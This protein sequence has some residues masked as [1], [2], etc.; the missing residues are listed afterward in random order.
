MIDPMLASTFFTCTD[1]PDYWGGPQIVLDKEGHVFIAG[2]TSAADFP[3]T[4]GAFDKSFNGGKKDIYVS[5]FDKDLKT[6]LASTIIGGRGDEAG[7][8]VNITTD[9]NGK[10]Y[11][12]GITGSTDYP[13]SQDAYEKNNKGGGT[14]VFVSRFNN[15]LSVLEASTYLGGTGYEGIRGIPKIKI[16]NNKNVYITGTTSSPDF[17]VTENAYK[18]GPANSSVRVYVSKFDKKLKKLESSTVIS[19][20]RG[21]YISSIKFDGNG[22]VYIAGTT[23][24]DDFPTTKGVYCEKYNGGSMDVYIS[25]FN[26]DLSKLICS[27]YLGA[28]SFDFCY[29]MTL[30]KNGYL[31]I[32]GHAGKDYPATEGAYSEKYGGVPDE[33]FI[34]KMDSDLK[35]VIASTFLSARGAEFDFSTRIA[36]D[37]NGNILLAGYVFGHDYP[38][39]PGAWDETFNGGRDLYLSKISNDL[40]TLSASTYIGGSELD[41]LG[42]IVLDNSNNIYMTGQTMSAD[43]PVTAGTYKDKFEKKQNVFILRLSSDLSE[44]SVEDIH[45]A[46]KKGETVRLKNLLKESPAL[47]NLKDKYQ[48]TPLHWAGKYG[49]PEIIRLLLEKGADINEKDESGRTPLHLAAWYNNTK[50]MEMLLSGGAE[51]NA[52]DKNNRT[53]LHLSAYYGCMDAVELLI[54]RK[55]L[56]TA[57]DISENSPLHLAANSNFPEIVKLLINRGADISMKNKNGE[58]PLHSAVKTWHNA[59]IVEYLAEKGAE[60]EAPDNEN[61]TPLITAVLSWRHD[62]IYKLIEK[63]ANV[64][65]ADNKGKTPLHYTAEQGWG[66]WQQIMEKLI[67]GGANI[68]LKDKDSKTPKDIAEGNKRGDI[69]EFLKSKQE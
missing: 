57:K 54:N 36:A 52:P 51:I 64:N 55:A 56:I 53:P 66:D 28:S 43:F 23:D 32:T 68:N 41:N 20:S 18:S 9:N 8:I 16:R 45:D 17:P 49:R 24:S 31:F 39:T 60:I 35:K 30:D 13:V 5:K 50:E 12:A 62:N 47:L 14:D 10:V 19:G 44:D 34:T 58:T 38:V 25:K 22:D 26:E 29:D 21:D 7:G 40:S 2:L 63:G 15:D 69:V 67:A 3:T 61:R 11:I 46:A 42:N 65:A 37:G 6:L 1:A 33:T 27:T 59:G 48:R 4:T